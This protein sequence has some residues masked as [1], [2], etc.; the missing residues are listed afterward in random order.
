MSTPLFINRELSWLEFNQRVLD[1]ALDPDVPLLDRLFFLTVTASNLD[2]FFMVRVG[3]L[4]L[5]D[6]GG[7][8]EPDPVGLTPHAQL[9]RIRTRVAA[10]VRDMQACFVD[11]LEP[12]LAH[13]GIR[14]HTATTLTPEQTESLHRRFMRELFPVFSPQALP[15]PGEGHFPTLNN[16]RLYVAAMLAP[17]GRKRIPRFALIPLNPHTSRIVP[18]P[19]DDNTFHYILLEDLIVTWIEAFFPGQ[20]VLHACPFRITRNADMRVEES[21]AEDLIEEM[22]KVL[23]RRQVSGCV[24]LEL[25]A[26]A[27]DAL[28]DYLADR[29][30]IGPEAIVPVA[31]VTD[32]TGLQPVA[33]LEGF[34]HLRYPKWPPRPNWRVDRARPMFEQIRKR[35]IPVLLPF[36]Q[37]DPVTRFIEEAAADPDTLA[38]KQVLYRVSGRSPVVAA[39]RR[40]ADA[41]KQVTVLV[42]LKARFDEANNIAWAERLER[43]GAQV[44]YGIKNLKTHAKICLVVRREPEGIVRYCHFGTGNYND[45]TARVYTDVGFLT[46]DPDLGADA[47]QFF[48]T[49]T[50]FSEPQPYRKLVQA[51]VNLREQLIE[52]IAAEAQR[53]RQGE[54]AGIRAKMNALVDPPVIEALYAAS[55]AGVDIRLNVRGTCCLRPGVKGLSETIRVVSI[56]DRFLEHSR[57]FSFH[58]GGNPLLFISSADWMPRNLSRR[59]ELMVPVED[60]TVRRMFQHVLDTC[61][62]DTVKGRELLDDGTYRPPA[63]TGAQAIRAQQLLYQEAV[64]RAGDRN[65]RSRT[66]FEPHLPPTPPEND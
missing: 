11:G 16:L 46:C 15:A 51:P 64:M 41:G 14:R 7:V 12:G 35:D 20:T 5:L 61:L 36:E 8:S 10:M 56:I 55:Q 29:L 26:R 57:I 21:F 18:V 44:I 66:V 50:G 3:G 49:V 17:D 6:A 33:A 22:K 53:A 42:E 2:E 19:S 65:R 62:S 63:P 28:R 58:H 37:F 30:R 9:H 23:A 45:K 40:A 1:E 24:R 32:L 31:A 52:L 48:N 60:K 59:I 47:S 43:A 34:D 39:L 4:Q 27:P 54:P 13:N 25:D 38:I